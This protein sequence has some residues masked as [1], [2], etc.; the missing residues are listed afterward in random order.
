MLMKNGVID[1]QVEEGGSMNNSWMN[2]GV[3]DGQINRWVDERGRPKVDCEIKAPLAN[4][5][6]HGQGGG[7][8]KNTPLATWCKFENYRDK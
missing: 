4:A 6:V 1:G 3:V 2:N 7:P 8:R 5:S